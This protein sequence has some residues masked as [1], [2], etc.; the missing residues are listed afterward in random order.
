M[1]KIFDSKQFVILNI[2]FT[3]K[4]NPICQLPKQFLIKYLLIMSSERSF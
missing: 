2:N 1:A 3:Y 4:I